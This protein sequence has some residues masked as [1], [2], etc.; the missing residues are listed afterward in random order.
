[1]NHQSPLPVT[2]PGRVRVVAWLPPAV[3]D[4]LDVAATRAKISS[5]GYIAAALTRHCLAIDLFAGGMDTRQIAEAL[6]LSADEVRREIGAQVDTAV[7][8]SIRR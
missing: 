7:L 1:M 6:R 2:E 8:G 4:K 3:A 5:S